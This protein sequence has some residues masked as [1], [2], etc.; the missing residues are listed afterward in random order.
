[1]RVG[2]AEQAHAHVLAVS[3]KASVWRA[4]RHQQVTPLVAPRAAAGWSR[5]SAGD[6]ATGPRGDAW[7]WLPL[8]APLQPHWCRGLLVRRSLS[9]PTDLPASVVCAP[10][11]TALATVGQVAGSRGTMERCLEEAQGEVGLEQ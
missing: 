11:A 6:G 3:G 5:V 7:R 10:Q 4:G 2:L 9:D 1:M 8:A